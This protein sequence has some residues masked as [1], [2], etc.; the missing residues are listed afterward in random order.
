MNN[1][2]IVKG[3]QES[4]GPTDTYVKRN[5]KR[6]RV[7]I[8]QWLHRPAYRHTP[9]EQKDIWNKEALHENTD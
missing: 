7:G 9:L 3:Y 1:E 8:G 5:P 6:V 2:G 4:A